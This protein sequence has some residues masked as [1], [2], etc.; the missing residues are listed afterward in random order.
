M[1]DTA[2]QAGIAFTTN[3]VCGMFGLF[4]SDDAPIER[5]EQVMATNQDTFARFFHAMLASGVYLAPSAF[6]AGFVSGAH[7]EATIDE[8][9]ARAGEAFRN[10]AA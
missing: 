7:E 6:E 8:T 4:F 10:I 3:H 5:Y 2:R 1:S 9:I